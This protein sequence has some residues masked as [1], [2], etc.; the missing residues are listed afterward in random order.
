MGRLS[1]LRKKIKGRL[2][3]AKAVRDNNKANNRIIKY[4]YESEKFR[5]RLARARKEGYKDGRTGQGKR[6]V[7]IRTDGPDPFGL[8]GAS[9]AHR[10]VSPRRKKRSGHTTIVIRQSG[11]GRRKRKRDSGGYLDQLL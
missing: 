5:G 2:D 11:S 7:S 1:N 9:T 8:F 10:T 4:E 3:Q 6:R